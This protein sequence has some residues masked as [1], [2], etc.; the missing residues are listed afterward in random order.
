[1]ELWGDRETYVCFLHVLPLQSI[2]QHSLAIASHTKMPIDRGALLTGPACPRIKS[3]ISNQL[4]GTN[5]QR[6]Y[7]GTLT[8]LTGRR[9][10]VGLRGVGEQVLIPNSADAWLYLYSFPTKA[11]CS[12]LCSVL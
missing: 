11:P 5:E 6:T 2:S 3:T 4:N 12:N 10:W 9:R 8:I 1:M 7:L